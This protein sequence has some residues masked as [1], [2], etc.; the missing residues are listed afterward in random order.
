MCDLASICNSC[1]K[2]TGRFLYMKRQSSP[3]HQ[4]VKSSLSLTCC[5]GVSDQ[6]EVREPEQSES[7]EC[8]TSSSLSAQFFLFHLPFFSPSFQPMTF[9]GPSSLKVCLQRAACAT[10]CV[11]RSPVS[12]ASRCRNVM[13]CLIEEEEGRC[14]PAD[15]NLDIHTSFLFNVTSS[16]C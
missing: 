15:T 8:R 12:A 3:L 5:W 2:F 14:P 16:F 10:F 4:P 11:Q 1:F 6:P 7:W 9:S 13:V